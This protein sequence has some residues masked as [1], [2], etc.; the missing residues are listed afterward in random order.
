VCWVIAYDT[1]YAM[2][3]RDEDL[4]IG[5]KS[6]A[7]LFG[8]ADRAIVGVLQAATLALLAWI[9]RDCGWVYFAGLAVA[10]MLAIRQQWMVRHREPARCMA[11]FL[12]NH[13]FGAVIFLGLAADFLLR[14]SAPIL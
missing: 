14:P 13:R 4:K 12:D 11:A 10:T 3:D 5:V 7:I 9:G 6:S 1:F 2:A 8:R